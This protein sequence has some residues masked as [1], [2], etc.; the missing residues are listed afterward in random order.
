MGFDISIVRGFGIS[1]HEAPEGTLEK[2][3]GEVD[4]SAR[5]IKIKEL[6]P[7]L[8]LVTTGNSWSGEEYHFIM[9]KGTISDGG[10]RRVRA[11][12]KEREE[13]ASVATHLP[14]HPDLEPSWHTEDR[15]V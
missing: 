12:K 15:I 14:S 11:T 10:G 4:T 6:Y 3:T 1:L 5:E 13:L 9:A 8:E 2:I 7:Q